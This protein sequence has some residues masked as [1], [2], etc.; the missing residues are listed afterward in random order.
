[1]PGQL[2]SRGKV[3]VRVGKGK[4]EFA[5]TSSRLSIVKFPLNLGVVMFATS[6]QGSLK[7]RNRD[8]PRP[9]SFA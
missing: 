4:E 3:E 1:M 9:S 8:G 5:K 6:L 7:G 2:L